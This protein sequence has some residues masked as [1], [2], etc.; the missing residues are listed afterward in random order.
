MTTAEDTPDQ[1]PQKNTSAETK[2]HTKKHVLLDLT[3]T[4]AV[5]FF[6][7]LV[8]FYVFFPYRPDNFF[9]YFCSL[10]A[11]IHLYYSTIIILA[12]YPVKLLL[13]A[14]LVRKNI[15]KSRPI[16]LIISLIFGV[17]LCVVAIM[18]FIAYSLMT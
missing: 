5:V 9:D 15:K 11:L 13:Q 8:S 18:D 10:Y 17:V 7:S 1:P 12:I 14:V 16:A 6:T 2:K 3:I 4:Y